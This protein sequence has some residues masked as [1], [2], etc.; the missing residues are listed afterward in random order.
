[1]QVSSKH[2][3]AGLFSVFFFS[4]HKLS[5]LWRFSNRRLKRNSGSLLYWSDLV[6]PV[7][8][9]LVLL[10]ILFCIVLQ[11]LKTLLQLIVLIT[12]L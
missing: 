8:S 5:V 7:F 1:M 4:S 12:F 6:E 10:V 3:F 2:E 9:F 11:Q